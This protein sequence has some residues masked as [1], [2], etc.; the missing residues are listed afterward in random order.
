ME[1]VS[2]GFAPGSEGLLTPLKPFFS[3]SRVSELLINKPQEVFVEREGKM[4]CHRIEALTAAHLKRLFALIANENGLVLDSTCPLLSGNLFDGSRV[5]L[6]IPPASKT[7][8]LAIRRQSVASMALNDYRNTSFFAATKADI[9]QKP[10]HQQTDKTLRSLYHNEHWADF[11]FKAIELKK[12]IIICGETSSGKTTFLNACLK[13]IPADERL[14]TLEDTYELNTTHA[15]QLALKA[16]KALSLSTPTITMQD[17]LQAALRL[18]PDRI[19][20]GE[21]RGKEVLDFISACQTGHEGSMTTLHAPNPATAINRLI[22]LYQMNGVAM[23]YEEIRTLITGVIDIILQL[24]PTPCGRQL[25]S[26][27]YRDALSEAVCP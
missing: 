19:I 2:N 18:R 14:I 10:P 16:P 1:G 9:G 24:K 12:T 20:M 21:L 22:Q 15:N 3:D 8:A 5:Q 25:S 4:T 13:A 17:L 23:T 27:W 6:V 7:Q 11:I 26:I